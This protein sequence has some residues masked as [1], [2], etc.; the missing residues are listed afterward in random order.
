MPAKEDGFQVWAENWR[1]LEIFCSLRHQWILAVGLEGG[2]RVGL[3]YTRVE[4]AF[5]MMNIRRKDRPSLFA[6]MRIMEDAAL[7]VWDKQ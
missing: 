7:D 3:D 6:D 4:S 1:S 5:N 2:K